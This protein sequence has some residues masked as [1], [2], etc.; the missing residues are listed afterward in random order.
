M[1]IELFNKSFLIVFICKIG[2]PKCLQ[3]FVSVSYLEN[4][5]LKSKLKESE[6]KRVKYNQTGQKNHSFFFLLESTKKK[7]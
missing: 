5:G 3:N 2:L 4:N 1:K 7:L 6:K